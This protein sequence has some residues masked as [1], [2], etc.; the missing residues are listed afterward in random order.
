MKV[1]EGTTGFI[2]RRQSSTA[3]SPQPVSGKAY[4]L[5]YSDNIN[6]RNIQARRPQNISNENEHNYKEKLTNLS[7]RWEILI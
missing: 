7:T 2:I 4:Y 6:I 5:K 3:A 1:A